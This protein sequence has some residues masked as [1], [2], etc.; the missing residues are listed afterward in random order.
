MQSDGGSSALE[1][2]RARS[3]I[4]PG[5][6]DLSETIADWRST[7]EGRFALTVVSRRVIRNELEPMLEGQFIDGAARR[8]F[9]RRVRDWVRTWHR[10]SPLNTR[11]HEMARAAC[12]GKL[13][14]AD[15]QLL[16][17]AA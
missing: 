14:A 1:V 11:R 7:P 17:E 10:Q 12:H 16:R 13:S 6:N 8:R 15:A 3:A 5:G 4:D 2:Q 9:G